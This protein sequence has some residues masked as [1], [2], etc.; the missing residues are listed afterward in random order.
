M[1]Q[2]IIDLSPTATILKHA[3]QGIP[4]AQHD[5]NVMLLVK[6]KIRGI[7][8]E[9]NVLSNLYFI[10]GPDSVFWLMILHISSSSS[11]SSK[12]YVLHSCAEAMM[13]TVT[14]NKSHLITLKMWSRSRLNSFII[15]K[16]SY[17]L[18][19]TQHSPKSKQTVTFDYCY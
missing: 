12:S 1:T 9:C 10:V 19:K 13:F 2:M 16:F 11:A 18:I 14:S 5:H 4:A 15:S 17:L 3:C 8:N 6:V 7:Q